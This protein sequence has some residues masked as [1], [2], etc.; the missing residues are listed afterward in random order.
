MYLEGINYTKLLN[1][2]NSNP[3]FPHNLRF[4][5]NVNLIN[6]HK[7]QNIS[8]NLNDSKKLKAVLSIHKSE[9]TFF[10]LLIHWMRRAQQ[11]SCQTSLQ[12]TEEYS[13]WKMMLIYGK[14]SAMQKT[15]RLV[16]Y[17][18]CCW[19]KLGYNRDSKN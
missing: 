5:L 13:R 4:I 1:L 12:Q 3:N 16:C 2:L 8:T 11:K 15:G 6:P 19:L 7:P 14:K 9:K 10:L 17:V 18:A